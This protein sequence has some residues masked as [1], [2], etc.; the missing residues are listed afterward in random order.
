MARAAEPQGEVTVSEP[1]PEYAW[2]EVWGWMKD[3][4]NRIM[5]D[6]GPQTLDEFV[7]WALRMSERSRTWGVWRDGELGGL[8]T[9]R[10][11]M[12]ALGEIHV[13]F[14]R[15]FWGRDTTAVSLRLVLGAVFTSNTIKVASVVFQ[16]N[17]AARALARRA[18][19]CE[20]GLF[21]GHT[22]RDGKPVNMVPLG[23]TKEGFNKENAID[24]HRGTDWGVRREHKD[25]QL[26][27]DVNA[28]VQP[29]AEQLTERA[30]VDAGE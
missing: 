22:L 30:G 6:F 29:G 27:V 26:D 8:I 7:T 11:A 12:P 16:D 25:H 1:F 20:E 17:H 15:S 10:Q 21:I 14:R 24:S 13:I 5:D 4:R 23:I 18:G 2:P 3:F 28:D 19:F 9:V